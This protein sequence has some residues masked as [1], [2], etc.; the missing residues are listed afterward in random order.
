MAVMTLSDRPLTLDEPR[1]T[2]PLLVHP[3]W[4]SSDAPLRDTPDSEAEE[5]RMRF[6]AFA[7]TM[8]TAGALDRASTDILGELGLTAGAFFALLE[9]E[10]AGPEGIAPSELARRLAVAR[11]NRHAL[12]RHPGQGGVGLARGASSRPPMVL[13][14]LTED[15]IAMLARVGDVYKNKLGELFQTLSPLQAE[16][17]RQLTALIPLEDDTLQSAFL[18]RGIEAFAS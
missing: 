8:R 1:P 12:R 3:G 2:A 6:T 13:A 16:R 18:L 9:L 7:Q 17:L 5:A 11:R 14:R 15:G 10:A 4:L